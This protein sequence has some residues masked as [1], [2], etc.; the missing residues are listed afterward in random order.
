M[1]RAMGL[2]YPTKQIPVTLLPSTS[3]RVITVRVRNNGTDQANMWKKILRT[4]PLLPL[5]SSRSR[6]RL[7]RITR[8][9]H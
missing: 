7:S 9:R 8:C 3:A 5:M 2:V 1:L 4:T 6:R